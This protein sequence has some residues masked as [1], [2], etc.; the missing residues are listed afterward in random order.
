VDNATY[1]ALV[2]RAFRRLLAALDQVDPDLIDVESTG[3]MITIT[4]R[5]GEKCIVNTQRAAHQLWVAGL[6][7][8]VHFSHDAQADLWKDDKGKGLELFGFVRD[9]VK[10][11]SDATLAY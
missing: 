10:A 7:Q 4:A 9:A 5:S 1:E 8:G 6:G 3:D 2:A 11:I